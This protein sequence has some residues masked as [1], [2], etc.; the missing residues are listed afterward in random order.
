[1]HVP[2]QLAVSLLAGLA[3]AD[4]Y[5]WSGSCS[6][7]S[8]LKFPL[9]VASNSGPCSGT[10]WKGDWGSN[11]MNTT[12]PCNKNAEYWYKRT[13]SGTYDLFRDLAGTRKV[14]NCKDGGRVVQTCGLTPIVCSMGRIGH[15]KTPTCN[16]KN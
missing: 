16:M 15:C 6:T 9:S 12:D 10:V 1:M 13:G 5:L 11:I 7:S 3:T 8:G 4:F 2:T 14:G